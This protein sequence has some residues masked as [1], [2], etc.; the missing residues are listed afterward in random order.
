MEPSGSGLPADWEEQWRREKERRKQVLAEGKEAVERDKRE[1]RRIVAFNDSRLGLTSERAEPGGSELSEEDNVRL[2]RSES[3][4]CETFEVLR[5]LLGS[6]L[7]TDLTVT[8]EDGSSVRVHASVLAAVSSLVEVKLR[9]EDPR[10]DRG[11]VA[12]RQWSLVLGPDVDPCGLRAV[13]E[14]AYTGALLA[15]DAL[16]RA[17]KAA[18]ALGV[19]RLL[20]LCDQTAAAKASPKR[21]EA[22]EEM[23]CTL[24]SVEQLREDGVGCDV[25]LDVSGALLHAHRVILAAGSDYFRGMFTSGM[26]ESRQTRVDLPLKVA[27]EMAALI[28]CCYRGSLPVNWDR[29]FELACAAIRFQFRSAVSLCLL[30]MKQEMG[31][32]SCL[33]VASFA[34]AYGMSELLEEAK[35]YVLRNF[36]E[37][38]ATEKFQDLRTEML[39]EFLCSDGLSVPSELVVFRALVSWL[40]ADPEQRLRHAGKL[41]RGV[42]FHLMTF[43]EFR[44]VRAINLRMETQDV[45]LHGAAFKEFGSSLSAQDQCR[46]RYPKDSLVL[47]GGDRL[48]PDVGQRLPSGEICFINSLRSGVGLVKD[49]EWRSLSRIPDRPKFRHGVVTI[50]GSL[51]VLGGC[52]FYAKDDVMKSTYSYDPKR[53]S[54]KRCSDMQ[55]RRSNFSAVAHRGQICAIGGDRQLDANLNSVEMYDIEADT[56]RFVRPLD[57]PLSGQA[58]AVLD[59]RVFISGGFDAK[60]VCLASLFLYDPEEERVHLADMI[61]DRA[62]HCMESLRGRLYVAGGVRNQRKFYTDQ[63]ACEVYDPAADCW[64]TLA[65]LPVPHVGAASAVLEENLYILGGYSQEDNS[66]SGLVHR[67]NRATQH[68]ERMGKV[69]VAVTDIR[70]CVLRLPQHLRR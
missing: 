20:D 70:A 25:I 53:D 64:T 66:E 12:P 7:L 14:F 39:L 62:Q 35:D 18:R 54:W 36:L 49:I 1:L 48:D 47:V 44:E 61:Q 13:L 60:Y 32:S 8:T 42:R 37:V 29:V 10:R 27:P 45:Q 6:G 24:R 51:F 4:P 11:E 30:F 56:W 69:P 65:A 38:S 52:H 59:G 67:Y 63:L 33:D 31:A 28:C 26:R 34:E 40:E 17:V 5:E 19:P 21:E 57:Q 68:W 3:F 16:P 58:A 41:M 43:R 2:Y 46:V 23:R 15:G 22:L 50:G 9:E 55:E